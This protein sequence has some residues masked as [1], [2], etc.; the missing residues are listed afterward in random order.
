[1]P[2]TDPRPMSPH[3]QI[4]RMPITAVLSV[5]HRATG[6]VLFLGLL[7]MIAVLAS[8]ASGEDNWL[9]MRGFL[10]SW[11]GYLILFGFTFSLY[12]HLCNGIRHL[13]WDIGKGLSVSSLHKS[14]IIV[15]LSSVI[16][17]LLTWI[18]A[19]L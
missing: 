9:I 15:L 19:L 12:Y 17:T 11:L 10:S 3:L 13:L 7:L 1:M 6:A 14:A 18:I 16:L 4:Y 5:L 2:W 8:I